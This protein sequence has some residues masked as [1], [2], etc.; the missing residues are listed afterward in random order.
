MAQAHHKFG[1]PTVSHVSAAYTLPFSY[2]DFS[3]DEAHTE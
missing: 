1:A 3:G 2:G